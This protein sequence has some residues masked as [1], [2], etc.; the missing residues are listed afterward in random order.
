MW[1]GSSSGGLFDI[2]GEFWLCVVT[3]ERSGFQ[4]VIQ[5]VREWN[6]DA[7]AILRPVIRVDAYSALEQE[8]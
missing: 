7:R 5:S 6:T 2:R 4:T 3:L 8:L 1:I